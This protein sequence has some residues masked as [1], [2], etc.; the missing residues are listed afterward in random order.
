MFASIASR[1]LSL[2]NVVSSTVVVLAETLRQFLFLLY[3]YMHGTDSPPV[4]SCRAPSF[5]VTAGPATTAALALHGS[6]ARPRMGANARARRTRCVGSRRVAGSQDRYSGVASHQQTDDSAS[7]V[8]RGPDR[9]D[10]RGVAAPVA[11]VE[12]AGENT[13]A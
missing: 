12:K 6:L 5:S 3:S 2:S 9:T 7:W 8:R 10:V 13:G 4:R 1:S 11:S